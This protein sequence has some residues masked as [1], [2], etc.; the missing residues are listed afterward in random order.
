MVWY[1]FLVLGLLTELQKVCRYDRMEIEVSRI[2]RTGK[3]ADL[4]A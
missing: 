2:M 1:P 3:Q 4:N